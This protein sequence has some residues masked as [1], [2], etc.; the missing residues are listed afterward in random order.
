MNRGSRARRAT[1]CRT[2]L[3]GPSSGCDL[4]GEDQ[5]HGHLRMVEQRIE[6]L[7]IL[8]QKVGALVGGK[9]PGKADGQRVAIQR[10]SQLRDDGGRLAAALGLH[11]HAAPR[12]LDQAGLERLMRLPQFAVV[13]FLD[14]VP[15]RR[16]AAVAPPS[17]RRGA[18]RRPAASAARATC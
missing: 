5:L 3:P 8:Q 1:S 7:E 14:R 6:R 18:G 4:P 10:A 13:D 12:H 2:V 16:V 17:W 11:D 9:P 15:E